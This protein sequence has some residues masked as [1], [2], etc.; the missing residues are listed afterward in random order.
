MCDNINKND[1]TMLT[2]AEIKYNIKRL[3]KEL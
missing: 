2:V 3:K 1:C